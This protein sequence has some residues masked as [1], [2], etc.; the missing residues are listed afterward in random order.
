MF[1]PPH[2]ASMSRFTIK[3]FKW[4]LFKFETFAKQSPL[5]SPKQLIETSILSK[6]KKEIVL[7]CSRET[8]P[9]F[10]NPP[11]IKYYFYVYPINKLKRIEIMKKFMPA[12]TA[13]MLEVCSSSTCHLLDIIVPTCRLLKRL[14]QKPTTKTKQTRINGSKVWIVLL[15]N[16]GHR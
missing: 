4:Y 12:I 7:R 10:F 6:H 5:V 13:R 3:L 14:P 16:H 2:L 15:L 8:F 1:F 9:S 11:N